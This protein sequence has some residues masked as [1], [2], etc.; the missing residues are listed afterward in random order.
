[1]INIISGI[2]CE[3]QKCTRIVRNCY[4]LCY[5]SPQKYTI[6]IKNTPVSISQ[7]EPEWR[8]PERASEDRERDLENQSRGQWNFTRV[9]ECKQRSSRFLFSIRCFL[10]KKGTLC[11]SMLKSS[12][13]SFYEYANNFWSTNMEQPLS[14]HNATVIRFNMRG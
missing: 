14:C 1:M 12:V 10:L 7:T 8:E 2:T 13:V 11:R 5:P 4:K 6:Q 3:S 9:E